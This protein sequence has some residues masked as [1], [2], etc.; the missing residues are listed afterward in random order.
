MGTKTVFLEFSSVDNICAFTLV[1]FARFK[2]VGSH[3]LEHFDCVTPVSSGIQC[4][5]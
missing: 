2:I 1:S 5:C 3:F 4:Y